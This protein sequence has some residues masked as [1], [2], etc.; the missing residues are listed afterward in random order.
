MKSATKGEATERKRGRDET[1]DGVK[2]SGPTHPRPTS[3]S[4][5]GGCPAHQRTYHAADGLQRESMSDW[6]SRSANSRQRAL[7]LQR[8]R[9][10]AAIRAAYAER[11]I[12]P[13]KVCGLTQKPCAYAVGCAW[14]EEQRQTV[15]LQ[16]GKS[17][18]S[19]FRKVEVCV[20]AS[21]TR[22]TAASPAPIGRA[23]RR[24]GAAS[25]LSVWPQEPRICV[26]T[27]GRGPPPTPPA[28]K[29]TA[30]FATPLQRV[31]GAMTRTPSK[32]R[33]RKSEVERHEQPGWS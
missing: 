31:F 26:L 11:G 18:V 14:N 27:G 7:A 10:Q 22:G 25:G 5:A 1:G 19:L 28:Q 33:G 21:G 29:A 4:S 30:R 32:V 20:W 3:A 12:D 23:A 16:R 15:R 13:S 8:R 24:C 17:E 9:R 2:S 6:A